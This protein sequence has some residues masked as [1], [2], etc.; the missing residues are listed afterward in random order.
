MSHT[1]PT[2]RHSLIFA[3]LVVGCPQL[4]VAEDLICFSDLVI[5]QDKYSCLMRLLWVCEYLQLESAPLLRYH[6]DSCLQQMSTSRKSLLNVYWRCTRVKLDSQ[7][8][9]SFLNL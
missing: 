5:G 9:V 7:F 1:E 3:M 8:S 6:Q 4:R 2:A